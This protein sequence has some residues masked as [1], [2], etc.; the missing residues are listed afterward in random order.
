VTGFSDG[1]VTWYAQRQ[2]TSIVREGA[3]VTS[4]GAISID[5]TVELLGG[6][7]SPAAVGIDITG[8]LVGFG[9]LDGSVV[10]AG[11]LA[12]TGDTSANGDLL[13][14]GS[15]EIAEGVL[16]VLVDFTCNG[17]LLADFTAAPLPLTDIPINGLHVGGR[18]VATGEADVLVRN[19][20]LRIGEALRIELTTNQSFDLS[21]ATVLFDGLNATLEAASEDIGPDLA[22]FNPATDGAFPLGVLRVAPS[23]TTTL[24]DD[25]LNDVGPAGVPA[26]V[27]VDHLIVE[28]NAT[29]STNGIPIYVRRATIDG[30]VDDKELVIIVDACPGDATGDRRV[31]GADL[32]TV[33]SNFG[34]PTSGGPESGD[35]APP[36]APDGFVNGA[37][38]VEV[39]ANFGVS[40]KAGVAGDD[41]DASVP[42]LKYPCRRS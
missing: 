3:T 9:S 37:D 29:L 35:V 15:I 5:R 4:G 30:A 24:V 39:L 22:G 26:A 27:Y 14:D 20:L 40:C 19:A 2:T 18:F 6:R 12:I 10:N 8:A 42:S 16:T 34:Q 25:V 36:G 11:S 23:S 13:N 32:V 41:H 38:L 21:H 28:A 7:M 31:D 1:R 17:A 33:L